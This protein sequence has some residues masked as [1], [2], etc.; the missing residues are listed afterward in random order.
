[1]TYNNTY[2]GSFASLAAL[3]PSAQTCTTPSSTNACLIDWLLAN[4]NSTAQGKSG[5]YFAIT[6]TA[7][8][9][10]SEAEPMTPGS[11]GTRGFCS[12]QN[13]VLYYKAVG[14]AMGVCTTANGT[15]L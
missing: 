13:L 1:V 2:P 14:G 9:Y 4:A 12:D 3:G 8:T 10:A 11:T 15:A 7:T 5:Y 6:T